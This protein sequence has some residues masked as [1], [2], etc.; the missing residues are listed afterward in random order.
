MVESRSLRAYVTFFGLF[1][2][3]TFSD[4]VTDNLGNKRDKC[5]EKIRNLQANKEYLEK[6]IKESEDSLREL[7]L[8]KK[9]TAA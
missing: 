7:I 8:S 9:N 2:G 4:T 6:S 1:Y 3:L 5:Q